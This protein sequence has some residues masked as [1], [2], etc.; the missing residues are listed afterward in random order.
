MFN[1]EM[2]TISYNVKKKIKCAIFICLLG[3]IVCANINGNVI[4]SQYVLLSEKENSSKEYKVKEDA[5]I[6]NGSRANTNYN[7]ENITKD[8]GSQ[9][10]D[11]NYRVVNTRYSGN[12]EIISMFKFDLPSKEEIDNEK[13]DSFYLEFS[14]FKNLNYNV[15]NQE[16]RF[17]YSTNTDW[18]EDK[19]TWNTK[20]N[21]ISRD[22]NDLLFS[23]FIQQGDE[24]EFKSNE[25]K[26]IRRD[27]TN[28]IYDLVS[29]GKT[30]ITVFTTAKYGANTGLMMHCKE[31]QAEQS[32][33][34]IVGESNAV[35][36]EKLQNLYTQSIDIDGSQYT[37][38]SYSDLQNALKE[39]KIVIDNPKSNL[40]KIIESF[41]Q[42]NSTKENLKKYI[43][44]AQADMLYRT[45]HEGKEDALP[46]RLFIPEN[47]SKDKSYP[48]IVF[49]HGAGER[50]DNNKD[51]LKNAIQP[52]FNTQDNA[53]EAIII[54]PQCPSGKRWVE[55]DWTKGCYDSEKIEEV[56]LASVLGILE[57]IKGEYSTNVDQIYAFGLSM[58]GFGTWD[59]ITRHSDIFAAAIPICGGGDPNKANVLKD[60][61]I[62][63]FHGTADPTV[64]YQGTQTMVNAINE[65]NGEKIKFTVYEGANHII[66]NQAAS[67]DGL[68]EWLFSH[69]LSDRYANFDNLN[70]LLDHVSILEEAKYRPSTWSNLQEVIKNA[71]AIL[72]QPLIGQDQVDKVSS[73]LDSAINELLMKADTTQ[74]QKVLSSFYLLDRELYTPSSWNT[75]NNEAKEVTKIL[76][77]DE[78]DQLDIDV[79]RIN[80]ENLIT[81]LKVRANTETLEKL[82]HE[83]EKVNGDLY[84][85]NSYNELVQYLSLSKTACNDLE[86]SQDS[87][88]LI[89]ASIQDA[90]SRL[91]V[92]DTK[93]RDIQNDTTSD[94]DAKPSIEIQKTQTVKTGVQE[95]K[96]YFYSLLGLSSLLLMLLGIRTYKK[97]N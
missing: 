3:A 66:W 82:I 78:V 27:I 80:I 14:I 74:L 93:D 13:L 77:N 48:V 75:V 30:Q 95:N 62:W 63:T 1:K 23:F 68:L 61:P 57:E 4:Y 47:Y 21:D 86:I 76:S 40:A 45:Y 85:A 5:F 81:K 19:I 97:S 83:I 60:V 51:Q 56:Q 53:K 52:L 8:H 38:E 6:R 70:A 10:V 32:Q 58:G 84:T 89:V 24:F 59:L 26:Y 41:H 72:K 11:L 55:T 42:L 46:Y 36:M 12:D 7:Y 96:Q 34:K 28:T 31:S 15:A 16:Y 39:A 33:P 25:E 22:N 50:G 18:Q 43:I 92:K 94:I 73:E 88:N 29:N 91:E 87:I 79:A 65:A 9:Y 49:L 35:T 37:K 2:N 90:L 71:K 64:P 20:P 67:E 17:H 54:A 69:K 44:D